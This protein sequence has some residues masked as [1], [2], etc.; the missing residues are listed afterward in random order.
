MTTLLTTLA[1]AAILA[2]VAIL[3]PSAAVMAESE[4]GDWGNE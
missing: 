1:I 4:K 2:A 3:Y